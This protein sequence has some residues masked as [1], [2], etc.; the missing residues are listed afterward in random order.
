MESMTPPPGITARLPHRAGPFQVREIAYAPGFRQPRHWHEGS[1]VTLIL[2][3]GIRE[4]AG[5]REEIGSALSVVVKPAGVEHADEVGPRGARTLQLA[6]DPFGLGG[7]MDGASDVTRW[8]WL[9][10]RPAAAAMLAVLRLVRR[11]ESGNASTLED[12][13]L[14]ALAVLPDDPPLPGEPPLWLRRARERLD[15][16]LH[17][18]P[19]VRDLA[20]GVGAHPVSLSRAFRRHYGCTI[21]EYRRRERLRRAAAA[22]EGTAEGLSRIAHQVGYADHAHLCREFRESAGVT[23]SHF[24]GIA[25]DR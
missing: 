1:S 19:S 11:S 8:R 2:S 9:H 15:D 22:I 16:D 25:R 14:D 7:L 4:A 5:S 17:R 12:G 3:G 13:I 20:Q 21:T 23:P 18:T 6:F 10:G 24:R